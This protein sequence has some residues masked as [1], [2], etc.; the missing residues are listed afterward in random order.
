MSDEDKECPICRVDM[1]QT[2]FEP[3][4]EDAPVCEGVL[5][6]RCG[7]AYHGT[8]IAMAFRAGVQCP[9]CRDNPEATENDYELPEQ[10][11]ENA[12]FSH[13]ENITAS[14]RQATF[15]QTHVGAVQQ[16]RA[17]YNKERKKL[18]M[19]MEKLNQDR[20]RCLAEA[21]KQFREQ[22]RNQFDKARKKVQRK[23][24]GV[25]QAE[26]EALES[27]YGMTAASETIGL[28][29]RSGVYSL[30]H[31]MSFVRNAFRK[32]FWSL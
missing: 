3:A 29:D 19:Y 10:N 26:W 9:M 4:S 13:I 28:L 6:L 2:V 25:R 11:I 12:V 20:H 32:S 30:E 31:Q 16:A 14:M 23:L 21:L 17:A 5:R 24:T 7:H 22:N 15:V 27:Y 18:T 8:C 1:G